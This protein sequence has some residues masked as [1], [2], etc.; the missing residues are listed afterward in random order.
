[1]L[2]TLK[3][4][5]KKLNDAIEVGETALND[6][7]E[8]DGLKVR[9]KRKRIT[10]AL[11]KA[12]Q[13][14]NKNEYKQREL[15]KRTDDIW[16]ALVEDSPFVMLWIFFFGFLLSGVLVFTVYQAYSFI[17]QCTDSEFNKNNPDL[18]PELSSLVDVVY[19]EKVI[20]LYDQ[21]SID[22]AEGLLNTPQEFTIK[23]N[24]DEVGSLQY[25]VNYEVKIVPLND[26]SAK[27]ISPKYIK[28]KYTYTDTL[29][30]TYYESPI[31]TLEETEQNSDGSYILDARS[32]GRGSSTTYSI[33][34]WISSLAPDEEMGSTYTFQFKV[35]A[36]VASA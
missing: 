2:N 36:A 3:E 22:D 28:Y 9:I 15:Y 5:V 32:Q 11:E 21:M 6:L 17:E 25:L 33:I 18:T 12:Y 10:K 1:M 13:T 35:D 27:L 8:D 4:E 7:S 19:T 14:L 29:S 30:G 31:K 34:F 20:N 26:P 16:D 23:N 24:P